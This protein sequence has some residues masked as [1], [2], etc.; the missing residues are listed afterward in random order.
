MRISIA[1]ARAKFAPRILLALGLRLFTCKF[2]QKLALV[3]CPCACR[4]LAQNG[5]PGPGAYKVALVTRPCAFDCA[6]SHKV[7]A[8]VWLALG[9]RP[10]PVISWIRWLL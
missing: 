7:C 4:W 1:Q 2:P 6:R 5:C 8:G 10:L 9:L 3:T